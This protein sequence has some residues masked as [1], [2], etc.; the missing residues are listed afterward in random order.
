VTAGKPVVTGA[1][2][3]VPGTGIAKGPAPKAPAPKFNMPAEE[4]PE[5]EV[6]GGTE[7]KPDQQ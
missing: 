6:S 1:K 3:A 7:W 2:P 4:A 5:F